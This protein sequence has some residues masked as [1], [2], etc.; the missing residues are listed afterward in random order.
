MQKVEYDSVNLEVGRTSQ[1]L[2]DVNAMIPQTWWIGSSGPITE[3]SVCLREQ[4][5]AEIMM[6]GGMIYG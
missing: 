3:N 4:V 1:K 6:A 2:D 5:V